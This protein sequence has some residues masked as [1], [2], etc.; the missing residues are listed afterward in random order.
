MTIGKK[1]DFADGLLKSQ[2]APPE[3]RER[4]NENYF[5]LLVARHSHNCVSCN[6][7]RT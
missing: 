5:I 6:E 7:D 4:L 3:T 1:K 2:K